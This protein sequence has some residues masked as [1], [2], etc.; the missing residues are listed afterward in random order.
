M[1]TTRWDGA[2]R[3]A[4]AGLAAAVAGAVALGMGGCNTNANN[5]VEANRA[6]TDQNQSLIAENE[7]L[8]SANASLQQAVEARDRSLSDFRAM[9]ER[10]RGENSSLASQFDEFQDR[11]RNIKFG[12]LDPVTDRALKD[13]A[14]QYPDLITY[15]ENRGMVRF[16]SDLTFASGSD[17]VTTAGRQSLEALGRI[18]SSPAAQGYDIKIV[19]HTDSQ[20][21]RQLPGRKFSDNWE[22][23]AFRSISVMREFTKMGVAP[24]R[25]EVAGRGE[26]MPAVANVGKGNTPQNRRVEI[27]L[28]KGAGWKPSAAPRSTPAKAN[29]DEDLMK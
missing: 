12:Q 18:L 25:L 5:L 16:T 28:V 20:R 2:G 21:V 23:S 10:L 29:V 7:T 27:F 6:L 14:A 24:E 17:E 19:G 8:R 26:W 11:L 1:S 9:I 13:L 4:R 22:L 15:D 3:W